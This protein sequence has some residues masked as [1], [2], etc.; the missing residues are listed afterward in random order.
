[1]A[2]INKLIPIIFK[3]E[4]GFVDDPAD[5][6]GATNMGVT[7]G[8]WRKVGYDKDG[9]G[10]IDVDDLKLLTREDVVSH[11]LRP[12]YWDKW[13]ADKIN[14]QSV[15]NILVDWVWASGAY[16]IKIPQKVLGVGIDG[17]V[18]PKTIAAINSYP[19]QKE[20]FEKIKQER[21]DFIDRIVANR[22]TNKKFKRGWLNRLNDI[23]FEL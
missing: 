18:G 17:I 6:G 22:P 3:W 5:Y 7:I 15:A 2:D 8:T 23:K 13:Q 20:L 4:G 14:N 16:G 19:D 1:M 21:I 9:D 11:V 10:V 12:Y